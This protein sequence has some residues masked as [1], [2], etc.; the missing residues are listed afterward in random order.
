MVPFTSYT[1]GSLS[2]KRSHSGALLVPLTLVLLAIFDRR[3]LFL[4][5]FSYML[6]TIAFALG[7]WISAKCSGSRLT[8]VGENMTGL[9]LKVVF[10]SG[11]MQIVKNLPHRQQSAEFMF[12]AVSNLLASLVIPFIPVKPRSK[13][14]WLWCYGTYLIVNV[15]SAMMVDLFISGTWDD[16]AKSMSFQ[17]SRSYRYDE[18]WFLAMWITLECVIPALGPHGP[19]GRNSN[20][21]SV[22]LMLCISLYH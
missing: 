7:S 11:M 10:C 9:S 13:Y 2:H 4:E 16:T 20:V 8:R 18:H 22:V 12:Q 3:S 5:N 6:A 1:M 17:D 14:L 21:K 19:F 15:L